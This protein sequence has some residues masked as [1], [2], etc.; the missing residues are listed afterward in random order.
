MMM[1]AYSASINVNVAL[2]AEGENHPSVDK[3][4]SKGFSWSGVS[5]KQS[6]T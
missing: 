6:E 1:A 2:D 3:I 5:P 4:F